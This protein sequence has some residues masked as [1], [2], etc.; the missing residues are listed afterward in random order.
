MGS[1][2]NSSSTPAM[3]T[4][5]RTVEVPSPMP[6]TWV[7]GERRTDVL[8]AGAYGN[9]N[10][11][12]DGALELSAGRHVFQS[13][14]F[15]P[16]AKLRISGAAGGVYIYVLGG[17]TFRGSQVLPSSEHEVFI[18]VLGT[19]TAEL[20]NELIECVMSH[21]TA[22]ND[23]AVLLGD[24]NMNG[25]L[26]NPYAQTAFEDAR[27]CSDPN[28]PYCTWL[29]PPLWKDPVETRNEWDFHFNRTGGTPNVNAVD[30]LDTWAYTMRSQCVASRGDSYAPEGLVSGEKC[31]V[32]GRLSE[33]AL[34]HQSGIVRFD[35][36][37]TQSMNPQ[38][39]ERLDYILLGQHATPNVPF[40]PYYPQHVSKAFNLLGGNAGPSGFSR[41]TGTENIL[42]GSDPITDHYGLNM[43]LDLYGAHISR[44]RCWQ[45]VRSQPGCG[46]KFDSPRGAPRATAQPASPQRRRPS[47]TPRPFV[48]RRR[49]FLQKQ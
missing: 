31:Q 4:F 25:D 27:D 34:T 28:V 7:S 33:N 46:C 26:S 20:A 23:I 29:E 16:A 49:P 38:G 44:A 14:A 32:V 36:G 2:G 21:R 37:A 5:S 48:Q 15:E 22:P 9:Y 30:L 17:F 1:R 19:G 13:L 47:Q 43:E 41:A 10:V 18:G 6:T 45:P 12:S 24:L 40:W 42:A 11:N 8:S 3:R 39:E 35:R